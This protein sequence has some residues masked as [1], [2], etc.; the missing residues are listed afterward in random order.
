MYVGDVEL[1]HNEVVDYAQ[2]LR[3]AGVDVEFEVVDGAV[4]GFENWAGSTT[5]AR[6]LIGRAQSWLRR[7]ACQ[8]LD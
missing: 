6:D 1:F 7:V 8:P 5:L 4:H 3:A 2:R